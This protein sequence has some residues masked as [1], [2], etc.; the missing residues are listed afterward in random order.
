MQTSQIGYNYNSYGGRS[1]VVFKKNE[2]DDIKD[3]GAPCIRLKG[4]LLSRRGRS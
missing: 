4:W 2:V 3:F 1:Y